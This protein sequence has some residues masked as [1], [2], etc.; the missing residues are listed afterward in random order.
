MS[1]TRDYINSNRHDF[2]NDGF[3]DLEKC[4]EHPFHLFESWLEV[5]I[6]KE[7]NEPYA[8]NLA[9]V[10]EDGKPHARILYVRD[11]MDQDLVFYTN[12]GSDKGQQVLKNPQACMTF[13]WPELSRQIRLEGVVERLDDTLSD[14]YFASRPRGSQIGAWASEQSK[15]L[16]SRDQLEARIKELEVRFEG[17]NVPRPNH[18]GGYRFKPSYYEFWLGHPSRLH[19]RLAYT[20]ENLSWIKRRLNP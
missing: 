10:D 13:F 18:W 3:L 17:Q 20:H 2:Y 9:T 12:Y 14:A 7:V 16:E 8:F 5:A 19:D 15:V 1:T 4:P 6:Q 11:L